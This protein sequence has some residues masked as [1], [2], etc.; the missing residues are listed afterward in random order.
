[1][2]EFLL[3]KISVIS[4]EEEDILTGNSLDKNIYTS[5][6]DFVVN[7]DKLMVGGRDISVRT[8]TRYTDFP[9]HK[10]N[11][12]EM[13]IVLGGS[14]THD[15]SN[16]TITLSEGDILIL[17]KH[18]LHSVRRADTPDIGVNII[19][20]DSFIESLSH[21]LSETVFSELAEENSKPNGSGIY[22]CFSAKGNKQIEN[23]VENLLFE[24]TEYSQDSSILKCTTSLLFDYLSRKSK[25]LLKIASRLPDKESIR[26]SSIIG[27]IRSY[28]REASLKEL[29]EKMFLS[30]P[31][32]SKMIT[33]LFGKSFKELLFEE[34]I[35]RAT[36]LIVKTDIPI[37]E[38]INNVGYENESYFHREF[39]RITGRTPLSLRREKKTSVST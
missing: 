32:L 1:M 39:K 19:I 35:R 38:I 9:L 30:P 14:I 27:Y 37:G 13:M 20:S 7:Y 12:L 22:L 6:S 10:H 16:E 34:R 11:Y 3:K 8:H 31:Y 28:Y 21:E 17:N 26:R 23:I 18:V 5:N 15:I 29:A 2:E 36:E 4:K 33:D 24:L 25:K